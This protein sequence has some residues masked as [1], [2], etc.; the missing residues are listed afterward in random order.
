[1][2]SRL[3]LATLIS[4]AV[5]PRAAAG[6]VR[7]ENLVLVTFDG[8][9][10]QEV[11]GG[12]DLEILKSTVEKGRVEDTESYKRYWAPSPEERRR[13]LMPFLWGAFLE[14]HGSIAG[15]R[16]RSSTVLLR[17]S[18]RFSYPGYAE[19]LCGEAHDDVIKS[20][21]PVQN[22]YPTVLEFLGARFQ[23]DS[24]RA[25]AFASWSILGWI[26]EQ[27]RGA[28]TSNAGFAAYEH[29]SAA[30]REL[31]KLQFETPTPWDSVRHDVYTF[32]FAMA[33]LESYTPRILYIGLGETDDWA[34]DGRYDRVLGA[35][36]R[37]DRYLRELWDY[38]ES[39]EAYRGKTTFLLTTDHGRGNTPADWKD[40]GA[41]VEGAQYVWFALASPD[42][43]RR[44]EWTD[45]GTVYH[46]QLAATLCRLLG[47]DFNAERPHAGKPIEAVFAAR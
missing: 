37:T 24:K 47:A 7:S 30:V 33:H 35:L 12:L 6:D 26:V 3:V 18:H 42:A 25:A 11:F 15:N 8:V 14:R 44:G 32:C 5:L 1:M 31:S 41:K 45:S 4:L 21:D 29:P 34:H 46:D 16:E 40:H 22:P 17:N 39:H 38:L 23:L 43:P 9:R 28:L 27:R 13:K 36:E 19:I 2:L 10:C 20:N